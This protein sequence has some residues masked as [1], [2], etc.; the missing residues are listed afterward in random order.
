L[1]AL[2]FGGALGY[3]IGRTAEFLNRV[4]GGLSPDRTTTD[5]CPADGYCAEMS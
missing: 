2:T 3:R 1:L 5:N 4:V